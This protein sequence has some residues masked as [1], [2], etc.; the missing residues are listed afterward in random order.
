[1]KK[2]IIVIAMSGGVDSSVSAALL[3]EKG[4]EVI[5]L[6][7]HLWDYNKIS[8]KKIKGRCCST[9]DVYDA[10]RVAAAIGIPHYVINLEENFKNIIVEPFI[11]SYL[12]GR[13]PS[14]CVLCNSH[15]KFHYLLEKAIA[16]G[17]DKLATG[18][19]AKVEYNEQI[20]R[21]VL[22]KG[23]DEQKD[24]SYFL[25][26]LSQYQLSKALFPLGDLT[27]NEVRRIAEYYKLPVAKKADSQQ[28]CFISD[29]NYRNF[30]TAN[31]KYEIK[32]GNFISKDGR[33]LGK[34]K[35]IYNYTIGQR[36]KLGIAI[37]KPLYVMRINPETNEIILSE[38]KDLYSSEAIAEEINWVSI[39]KPKENF[40]GNVRIRYK[41][42]EAPATI[43]PYDDNK[44]RVIFDEKQR[45]ITS[46]QA[47]VIYQGDIVIGGGWIK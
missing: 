25:F 6:T 47:L 18:H 1:M 22:K 42:Q 3:K 13:T 26:N 20:E 15:L 5:G 19:Y 32:E 4:F 29:D 2:E 30:I 23:K 45:A 43:I 31:Y 39:H 46:G 9:E 16:L 11:K 8:G 12:T 41:H 14:P 44:I 27:K 21:W 28:L 36:R 34:H 7:M 17:A 38:E 33:I 10:R 24:Q 40:R 37:G 35:G